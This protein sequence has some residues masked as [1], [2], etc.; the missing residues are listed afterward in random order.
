MEGPMKRNAVYFT[1]DEL[2]IGPILTARIEE[3]SRPLGRRTKQCK[4]CRR[5]N[6][7]LHAGIIHGTLFKPWSEGVNPW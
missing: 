5:K 1:W 6:P 2:A 7:S 4:E 3:S